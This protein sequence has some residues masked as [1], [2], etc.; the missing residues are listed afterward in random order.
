M[1]K[2]NCLLDWYAIDRASGIGYMIETWN[3]LNHDQNSHLVHYMKVL[4]EA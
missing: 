2:S 1:K 3:R 4:N